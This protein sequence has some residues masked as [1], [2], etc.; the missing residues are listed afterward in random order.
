MGVQHHHAHVAS[1]MAEHGLKGNVVGVAFDGTGLGDDGTAWGGEILECGPGSYARRCTLR[2]IR[3]A[4]GD[5]AMSEGL[6]LFSRLDP[7]KVAGVRSLLA[8]G[9]NSPMA[10]GAGRY[11]DA[12]GA[13]CLGLPEARFE[14][15][16]AIALNVAASEEENGVYPFVIDRS[17]PTAQIDLR[18]MIRRL[19]SDLRDDVP[20]EVVAARFHDTLASATAVFVRENTDPALPVVLTGGCFQNDRLTASLVRRLRPDRVVI[21][22]SQVP[23]GDGGLALGQALV[24]GAILDAEASLPRRAGCS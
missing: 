6:R 1:A 19:V 9:L 24:A 13:L 22:H 12:L 5:R 23:C 8:A 18:P 2:P 16:V 14:G 17:G 15:Q 21:L 7:A 4:G 11:F 3:L 10:H 20:T